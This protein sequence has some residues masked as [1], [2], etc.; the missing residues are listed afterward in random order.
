MTTPAVRAIRGA[1][2]V[3]SDEPGLIAEATLELLGGMLDRNGLGTED[4]I[5][6]LFTVSGDL[7]SAFPATAA[8]HAGFAEVPLLCAMEIP[9][10]GSQPRCIRAMLHV[11]TTRPRAEVVHVYL[12]DAQGLRDDVPS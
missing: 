3:D 8:R 5:S 6:A 2:T 9:V 7:S 12:R 1:T 10:P 11:T 4:V